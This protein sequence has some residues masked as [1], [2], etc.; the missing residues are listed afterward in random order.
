VVL[1]S[2]LPQPVSAMDAMTAMTAILLVRRK[3]P[4]SGELMHRE[5]TAPIPSAP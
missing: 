1:L 3:M 4:S 2:L 5:D